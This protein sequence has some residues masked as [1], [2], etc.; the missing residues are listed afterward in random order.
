MDM[1]FFEMAIKKLEQQSSS[2]VERIVDDI[3][4]SLSQIPITNHAVP[5]IVGDLNFDDVYENATDYDVSFSTWFNDRVAPDLMV[6]I[7]S[8]IDER[9]SQTLSE[10]ATKDIRMPDLLD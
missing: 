4:H 5:L 9:M 7:K 2:T 8:V 1:T 10:M 6:V 3:K